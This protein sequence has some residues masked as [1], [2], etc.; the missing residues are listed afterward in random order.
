MA[1]AAAPMFVINGFYMSM[2]EKYTK[3][4][5]KIHYFVVEWDSAKLSW[6]DFRGQAL[7]AT[8][9]TLSAKGSLRNLVLE[10]WEALGLSALPDIGDNGVHGSASPFEALVER[11]NWLGVDIAADPFG[12]A[13]LKAGLTLE[14][15]LEY[16]RDPQVTFGGKKAGLFDSLED[17]NS[18]ECIQ[19]LKEIAGVQGEAKEDEKYTTNSAFLFLKPHAVTPAAIS[20]VT[21]Q[22]AALGLTVTASGELDNEVIDKKKLID[23]HYYAIA[24]KASLTKPADL[25]PSQ[26]AQ[27][28]FK[29]KWGLEWSQA[30]AD[31]LVFNAFDACAKRG[32]DGEQLN[33]VWAKAKKGDQ[34]VKFGGGFYCGKL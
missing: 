27:D 5:A 2:R 29:T 1:D 18:D 32:V 28:E 4:G 12:A 33:D 25:E 17:V 9:P 20:L 10:R 13:L 21:E 24:N 34:L 19:R 11:N 15:L 26:K 23:N 7:G 22:L 14:Q 30:V 31:G 3:A 16:R 6:A 8:D